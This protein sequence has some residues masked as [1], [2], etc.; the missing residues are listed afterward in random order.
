MEPP[1]LNPYQA[2]EINHSVGSL[3]KS[4][5]D[6]FREMK[7][8]AWLA[9]VCI[10]PTVPYSIY[11]MLLALGRVTVSDEV[12][13]MI[14]GLFALSFITGVI[15][16]C[17]WKY[18]CACNARYFYGG[19]LLYTPGWCVGY[20]FIPIMMLFRP[21]QCMNDIYQKT[22]LL[23]GGKSPFAL[24]LTWWLTWIFSGVA[25]RIAL[26]S[27]AS[28]GFV[29]SSSLSLVSALL[30]IWVIFTLTRRQYE[31]IS[32][33]ELAAKIGTMNPFNKLKLAPGVPIKRPQLPTST[34]ESV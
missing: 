21:F 1:S 9:S 6:Q 10:A 7:I 13:E 27:K 8:L 22:Y 5:D 11:V 2:P 16:Y 3:P 32:D 31:I 17:I 30:A 29:V 28:E 14:D 26:A 4:P 20:Y 15:F 33:P 19:P 12:V 25:D 18:R 34:S 23:F 24:L